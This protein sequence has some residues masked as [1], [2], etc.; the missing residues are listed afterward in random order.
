MEKVVY[1]LQGN[2]G[3]DVEIV[4]HVDETLTEDQRSELVTVLQESEGIDGAEFCGSRN[5][6]MLVQYDRD[7]LSSQDVLW[8]VTS[9]HMHAEL[10]GP[11]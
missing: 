10:V 9:Q 5:H 1:S 3:N 6:L 7:Q 4:V 8:R 2:L 11:V